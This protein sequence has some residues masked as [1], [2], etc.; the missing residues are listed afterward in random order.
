MPAR[1]KASE[2]AAAPGANKKTSPAKRAPRKVAGEA[3]VAKTP[4]KKPAAAAPAPGASG[5]NLVIV[6]SP[7]KAKTIQKYLGPGFE[8][9][10]SVGHIRDLAKRGGQ[11]GIGIDID[12]GWVPTY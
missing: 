4:R 1:K 7:A 3:P 2:A 10:A 5:R 9:A 11:G 12:A 8:V 6:E